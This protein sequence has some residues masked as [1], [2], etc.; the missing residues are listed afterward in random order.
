MNPIQHRILAVDG[1]RAVAVLA[2]I[3]YHISSASFPGG[4]VGV[5]LF[6]V[7]SGYVVCGSLLKTSPDES[8]SRLATGFYARRFLRIYPPLVVM[9]IV[10]GVLHRIFVPESTLAGTSAQT[11]NFAFFGISNIQLIWNTEPYFGPMAEFNP[12]THTWSLAVEEQFYFLFPLVLFVYLRKRR[13]ALWIF[14][15]LFL[16]SCSWA[17]FETFANPV[18][19]FYLLPSRLWE[20]L[21]GS[22][23][24]LIHRREQLLPRTSARASLTA[25]VGLLCIAVSLV[26]TPIS[27]FPFPWAIVP[28]VGTLLTI[29]GV[30]GQVGLPAKILSNAMVVFVG[31]ISYSLYLWHWPVIVLMRWTIGVE[32]QVQFIVAFTLAITFAVLSYFGIERVAQRLQ[33][34][35]DKANRR[36]LS[37]NSLMI[38]AAVFIIGSSSYLYSRISHS[39]RFPLSVTMSEALKH[40][41]RISTDSIALDQ[42]NIGEPNRPWSGKRLF[43]VG[44]SHAGSYREMFGLLR[45]QQGVDVYLN[46]IGGLRFGSL[47]FAQSVNDRKRQQQVLTDIGHLARPGDVIF[48]ASLRVLRFGEPWVNFPLEK[49]I[50]KRD[51]AVAETDRQIAI[52]EGVKLIDRLRAMGLV[53]IVDAPKPLYRAPPFRC[54]DWF[55]RMNSIGHHGFELERDFLLSH[56]AKAMDSIAQIT[57]DDSQVRVWDPFPVLCPSSTCSA[58]DAEKPLFFD[59]D[60]LSGHGN[61]LLYPSFKA[62]L[63][64]IWDK[65]GK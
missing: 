55:N 26:I 52:T 30:V 50:A 53:V 9:L 12:Y 17:A 23:L 63:S 20:L 41:W 21:A 7:I 54:S 25:T 57:Q 58:F 32:S 64:E 13:V 6:F 22:I 2:V 33:S 62:F 38:V 5:D 3:A 10:V 14:T 60:H 61:R 1:L 18:W 16:S 29:S 34:A 51:S 19:A 46:T 43:V 11:G 65:E 42:L 24:C 39:A 27:Q 45:Q 31:R 44:D 49:V 36:T 37:A 15:A 40:D 35:I 56:R 47:M 4:F 28:T 8:F 48:L 59:G